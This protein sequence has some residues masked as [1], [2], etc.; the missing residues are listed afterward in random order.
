MPSASGNPTEISIIGLSSVSNCR[1]DFIF[2]SLSLISGQ[3]IEQE[4]KPRVSRA[5]IRDIDA[6]DES[7]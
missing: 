3:L 5:Y 4:L 2:S 6:K 1:R 7:I